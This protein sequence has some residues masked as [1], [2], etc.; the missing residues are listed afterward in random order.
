[1]ASI[2]IRDLEDD[3]KRRLKQ[4]ANDKGVSMEAEARRILEEAVRP[5]SALAVWRSCA[6]TGWRG[7]DLDTPDRVPDRRLPDFDD[8]VAEHD[9]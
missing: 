9:A 6:P 7:I 2:T 4:Q 3:V 8:E 1:M 5:Q